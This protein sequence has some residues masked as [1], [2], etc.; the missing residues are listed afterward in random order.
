[1]NTEAAQQETN[2]CHRG[3]IFAVEIFS[4]YDVILL[5]V[6]CRRCCGRGHGII[7]GAVYGS[8]AFCTSIGIR[9]KLS[10]AILAELVTV[11]Y[12][13]ATVFTEFLVTIENYS[14][15]FAIYKN[16]LSLIDYGI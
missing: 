7:C 12:L 14:T 16:N 1:M 15:V 10:A 3:F 9:S 11:T 8:A 2:N 6:I 4:G 5:L 13:N